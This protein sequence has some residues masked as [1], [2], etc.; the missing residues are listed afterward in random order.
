MDCAKLN[1]EFYL[2]VD[3][4]WTSLSKKLIAISGKI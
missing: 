4:F 3:P 1:G 2:R